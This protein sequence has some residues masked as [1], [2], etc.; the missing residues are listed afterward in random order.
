MLK[1][2]IIPCLTIKHHRLVKSVRFR[3]HRN[4]GSYIA[5]AR[6]FNARDVDEMIILDLDAAE[7][8][9][10]PE[11]LQEIAKECF[12]PLTLGGGVKTTDDIRLLL[13]LGADK[14]AMN[15][16][17]FRVPSLITR[18]AREFGSQCVVVSI[19]AQKKDGRYRVVIDGGREET[20]L[21]PVAWAREA[22]ARGA[23]ELFLTSIDRDGMMQ[24][25]DYELLREVTEAVGIP[26]IAC[27]G[28]GSADDCLQAVTCG[29][30]AVAAASIFQYTEITP[31]DI[32]R[33]LV[34]EGVATRL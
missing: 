6:V 33:R 32:K 28:A 30:S 11:L 10:N 5:A 1:T 21:S 17:A 3:E 34:A 29:A 22:E 9:V 25:Y 19:D 4:I 27:G 2:R 18:A 8:G 24:G 16:A 20:A 12:M 31:K 7:G 15:T 23:G 26:V 13:R 14:I